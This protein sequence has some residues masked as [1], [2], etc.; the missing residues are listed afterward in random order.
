MAKP[1]TTKKTT[2]GEVSRLFLEAR[3]EP[4]SAEKKQEKH[5][6]AIFWRFSLVSLEHPLKRRFPPGPKLAEEPLPIQ[7]T[8]ELRLEVA[9]AGGLRSLGPEASSW[10]GSKRKSTRNWTADFGPGFFFFPRLP[11]QARLGSPYF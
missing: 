8:R 11:G 7:A 10:G 9:E 3:T 2:R 4:S 1:P 6:A 5:K